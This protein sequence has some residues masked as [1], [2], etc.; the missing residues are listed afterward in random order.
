MEHLKVL[1]KEPGQFLLTHLRVSILSPGQGPLLG[2]EQER[3]LEAFP[4]PQD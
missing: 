1:I 4:S 2:E 3:V